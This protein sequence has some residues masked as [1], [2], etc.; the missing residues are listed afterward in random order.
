[1]KILNHNRILASLWQRRGL[2]S[3]NGTGSGFLAGHPRPAWNAIVWSQSPESHGPDFDDEKA[4]SIVLNIFWFWHNKWHAEVIWSHLSNQAAYQQLQMSF[5]FARPP[6]LRFKE[7]DRG[8]ATFPP[9]PQKMT[10][11]F[12]RK[13]KR[14]AH[15]PSVFS[16]Q[17]VLR[18]PA[19]FQGQI[20][21]LSHPAPSQTAGDKFHLG[22]LVLLAGWLIPRSQNNIDA[23]KNGPFFIF[24]KLL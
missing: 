2:G 21:L 1:M 10:S 11:I 5:W 17:L 9:H 16:M 18:T 7:N 23:W 6:T 8:T 3:K 22:K 19:I 13:S 24:P 20:C 4:C 14:N 12:S 15:N